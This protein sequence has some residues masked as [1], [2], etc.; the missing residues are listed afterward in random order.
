MAVTMGVAYAQAF[1][2]TVVS[3]DFQLTGDQR[4]AVAEFRQRH[5]TEVMTLLFTDVIGSTEIK[6]RLGE[7]AG[8]ELL[9]RHRTV[10][11]DLL[12][13]FREAEEIS[14]AGDSFFIAFHSPS[15]A[16]LFALQLQHALSLVSQATRA[17]IQVRIGIHLG[18]VF[19]EEEPEG[20]LMRDL[21]GLQVDIASRVTALAG[22]GQV[23]LTRAIFDHARTALKGDALADLAPLSWMSHGLYKLKGD[24]RGWR[25]RPGPARAAHAKCGFVTHIASRNGIGSWLAAG[26]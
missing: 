1:G 11:R 17:P 13:S 18:K 3:A 8:I 12:G 14:T 24:L 25:A 21:W 19:I 16:V 15:D 7:A 23:L 6:Q 2:G 10:V 26:S 22:A 5:P 4:K 9:H 20:A